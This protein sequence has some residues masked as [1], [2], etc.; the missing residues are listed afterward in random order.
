[1][2]FSISER[3]ADI[4]S[5]QPPP[6]A[7]V[8]LDAVAVVPGGRSGAPAAGAVAGPAEGAAVR[9]LVAVEAALA[10]PSAEPDAAVVRPGAVARLAELAAVLEPSVWPAE[11][12]L[13]ALQRIWVAVA[14]RLAFG[15]FPERPAWLREPEPIRRASVAPPELLAHSSQ[16]DLAGQASRWDSAHL[17]RVPSCAA[18][19]QAPLSCPELAE[20]WSSAT[21]GPE[22]AHSGIYLRAMAYSAQLSG[23]TAYR[24][25]RAWL[26]D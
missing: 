9:L 25:S 13:K 23:P 4:S 19:Q 8:A 17:E 7:A 16:D 10:S 18:A 12:A 26:P 24:E 1:L 3:S 21:P 6:V 5:L 2:V 20:H 15:P 14:P 11:W 22:A